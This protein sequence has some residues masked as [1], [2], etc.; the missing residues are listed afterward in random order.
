MKKHVAYLFLDIEWNQTPGT[1]DLEGREAIQIG[2][3]AADEA[4]KKVKSFLKAI[5]LKHPKLLS[6][7]TIKVTHT[8]A[9]NIM[10]AKPE[11]IVLTNFSQTFPEYQYIVVWS[12]ETYDLFK[13]DMKNYK[14]P[15][16][17]HQVIVL[18]EMIN[19]IAGNGNKMMGF[20]LAL[21]GAGI[22]YIP[23]YLH[24]SKHDVNYLY[25]LF[26]TCRQEFIQA[27]T[28]EYCIVNTNTKKLHTRNC[29]YVRNMPLEKILMKP[30]SSIFKG[31]LICKC[32]GTKEEW[33]RLDWTY[34]RKSETSS[35]KDKTK[36][37]KQLPLTEKNIDIICRHFQVS[38]SVSNTAVFIC[39]A[40]SRYCFEKVGQ[41]E[42]AYREKRKAKKL[43]ENGGEIVKT[44]VCPHCQTEF[45]PTSNRQVFCTK[46]C[47][48]QARQ[49]KAK[50]DRKAE[51]GDHYYRQRK[52]EVRGSLYCIRDRAYTQSTEIL[53]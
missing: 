3:V 12:R 40:Y 4:M 47:C 21:I 26:C 1:A 5:Q 39:T 16:Q 31:Y 29:R 53:F 27:T 9:N 41:R 30:K 22:D 15:M 28:D 44:K 7:E 19:T 18:Q 35:K 36:T 38:Y 14:I 10:Q 2:V 49:D 45:T 17:K 34:I 46:E 43:A 24:Y 52:C 25:Q 51:K 11:N 50:A 8:T 42:K 23:N 33:K 20:E 48:K 37:L 13:R 32:C 6:T